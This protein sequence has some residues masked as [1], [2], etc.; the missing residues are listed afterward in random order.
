MKKNKDNYIYVPT[1]MK[2]QKNKGLKV[3]YRRK[4]LGKVPKSIIYRLKKSL[5][6]YIMEYMKTRPINNT[7]IL[8]RA[9]AV[10][11]DQKYAKAYTIIADKY[12]R[13]EEKY[14]R[15]ANDFGYKILT[16]LINTGKLSIG[17][18]MSLFIILNDK[19]LIT[20]E[21]PD[22]TFNKS[23]YYVYETNENTIE[24]TEKPE[25][26]ISNISLKDLATS[27]TF[28]T[29][30]M[31]Y[32]HENLSNHLLSPEK[33]QE[34]EHYMKEYSFYFNYN[35]EYLIDVFK[36]ATDNYSNIDLVLDADKYDLT[37]PETIA[38]IFVYYFYRD[39][40]KYLN[41]D[42][43]DY[44]YNSKSDFVTTNEIYIIEPNWMHNHIEDKTVEKEDIT[45][46]NGLTYSEYVGRMCDLI[47]I[48][49]EYKAYVLGVSYA[50]RGKFGSENSI[51]LNNMGGLRGENG[52]FE[53]PCPEAGII[54]FVAN[55]RRYEWAFNIDSM[56]DFGNTYD[57]DEFVDQWVS[58]VTNFQKEIT[59]SY[60]DF[61]LT[62]EEEIV[63][64][65]NVQTLIFNNETDYEIIKL[66]TDSPK[67]LTYV[68]NN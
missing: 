9:Q 5:Y 24:L 41:I 8:N 27:D 13:F 16:K 15:Y 14:E 20:D 57:G 37:N 28:N 23:S 25:D 1:D 60:P 44:G 48:P 49:E 21:I 19:S 34:F 26:F 55:I 66:N 29:E 7:A 58:N 10:I 12:D 11:L 63:Y 61:F 35:P 59:E 47:G 30:A 2:V 18:A 56:L 43:T 17:L 62:P 65:A 3:I 33:Q 54:A 22:E 46:R 42:I 50:E 6:Q 67:T 39:P 51:Y 68:D 4:Y 31:V 45:L 36:K 52:Y 38:I 32:T 40:Q 64:L 53:Y